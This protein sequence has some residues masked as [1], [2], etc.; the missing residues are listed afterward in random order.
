MRP[1]QH[2]KFPASI[3]S[4]LTVMASPGVPYVVAIPNDIRMVVLRA[5]R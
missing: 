4:F 3:Y 1:R 5:F 2:G